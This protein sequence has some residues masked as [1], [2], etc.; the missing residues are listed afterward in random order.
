MTTS[1]PAGN[2]TS[3]YRKPCIRDKKLLWV[4]IRKCWSLS[5]FYEKI[6]NFNAR[7]S[8]V[9]LPGDLS[10]PIYTL[11]LTGYATDSNEKYIIAVLCE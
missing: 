5:D 3:L 11:L 8:E 7:Y 6:A 4:T 9:L 10:R 2:T 1:Y